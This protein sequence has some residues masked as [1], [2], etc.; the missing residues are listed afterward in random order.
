M[1]THMRAI[2]A[3]NLS[4][5]NMLHLSEAVLK[6]AMFEFRLSVLVNSY[7][8]VAMLPPFHWTSIQHSDVM[9]PKICLKSKYIKVRVVK[10]K[11]LAIY[12]VLCN[13]RLVKMYGYNHI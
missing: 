9:A 7:G 1:V 10:L 4:F 12:P 6:C 2:L 11:F 5:L 3:L 8:H 13:L